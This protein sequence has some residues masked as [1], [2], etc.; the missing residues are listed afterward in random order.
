MTSTYGGG[1]RDHLIR[2]VEHTEDGAAGGCWYQRDE[3]LVAEEDLPHV[4][5]RAHRLVDHHEPLPGTGVIRLRLRPGAGVNVPELVHDLSTSHP[6]RRLAVTANH[7]LRGESGADPGT[8]QAAPPVY[9]GGPATRPTPAAALAAPVRRAPTIQPDPS[10][11]G[12]PSG[13]PTPARTAIH[14]P[15]DAESPALMQ[16][17]PSWPGAEES[18]P[19]AGPRKPR[20]SDTWR[21]GD[22]DPWRPSTQPGGQVRVAILDT[23][24]SPHPW[25][26]DSPWYAACSPDQYEIVD[27][28]HDGML[29]H[30]AGHGT[31]IAGLVLQQAP[32]AYLLIERILRSDG[33]CDEALLIQGL[34]RLALRTIAL[35]RPVHVIN[36]SLGGYA[37]SDEPSPLLTRALGRF[38]RGTVTVACAGNN[39]SEREFWPGSLKEVVAVGA[40]DAS[41]GCRCGFSNYGWWVDA[42]TVGEHVT[43]TFLE[44]TQADGVRF[45]GFATWSGT[46]FAAPQVAGAVAQIAHEK[47][48]RPSDAL[49]FV[50]D[51]TLHPALPDFGVVVPSVGGGC[52][53]DP[54]TS[55][56][57][58]TAANQG[59][60]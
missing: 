18:P 30:E 40:L 36:L 35:G 50:L 4:H 21:T 57:T 49:D 25:W 20:P 58:A 17:R 3:V 51:R 59:T 34:G 43:S 31:F 33:Y 32:D 23:G 2:S 19:T 1:A 45:D 6:R 7:V 37:V 48:I 39:N 52:Q 44:F 11:P 28:D 27:S 16:P 12:G 9:P 54:A 56:L 8:M 41:G 55:G 42:C 53:E 29:D 46:S 10:W 38:G 22:Q 13:A 5:E 24:I 47:D 15:G 60:P 26:R 14:R